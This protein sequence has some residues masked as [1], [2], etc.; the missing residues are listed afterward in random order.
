MSDDEIIADTS[1]QIGKLLMVCLIVLLGSIGPA[2][3]ILPSPSKWH[4]PDCERL[5]GAIMEKN[6]AAESCIGDVCHRQYYFNVQP[7]N[8]NNSTKQVWV[9]P[10]TYLSNE[11]GD[12]YDYPVC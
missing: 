9:A 1:P 8:N 2:G 10:I 7:L 5:E 6:Y 4:W 11:V 3:F 12:D